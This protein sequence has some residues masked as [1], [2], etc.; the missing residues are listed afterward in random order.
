MTTGE[1]GSPEDSIKLGEPI[2]TPTRWQKF[3]DWVGTKKVAKEIKIGEA[4]GVPVQPTDEALG[5]QF[6]NSS[7]PQI[8]QPP[9]ELTEEELLRAIKLTPSRT[10]EMIRRYA[11]MNQMAAVD[12]VKAIRANYQ[13]LIPNPRN[14]YSHPKEWFE[15]SDLHKLI[16]RWN[17]P[18]IIVRNPDRRHYMLAL[19]MPEMINGRW[20]V[21]VYDS[22][23]DRP[24]DQSG[25]T[26]YYYP[27]YN[28]DPNDRSRSFGYQV[29]ENGLYGNPLTFQLVESGR[30]DLRLHG[31]EEEA[32]TIGEA[33]RVRTQFNDSDCGPLVLFA[34]AIRLAY[35]EGDN[36]FKSSGKDILLQDTGVNIRT[37][38]EIL[39]E[40]KQFVG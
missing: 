12:F 39:S 28:W 40:A 20:Q 35:K 9:R 18:A 22:L 29:I 1:G 5:K 19:N 26:E 8:S 10:D 16:D 25:R 21:L 31:D 27:L 14:D 17:L 23:T 11:E 33:K 36:E 13:T 38:E 30:Y 37:R 3:K 7:E 2:Q 32:R 15:V 24:I 6:N 34:A 4:Y